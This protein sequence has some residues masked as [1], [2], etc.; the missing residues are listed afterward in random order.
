MAQRV[1]AYIETAA[2]WRFESGKYSNPCQSSREANAGTSSKSI[3][4]FTYQVA[5]CSS[6][7]TE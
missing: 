5:E 4:V 3:D 2:R 1:N 7:E 6:L